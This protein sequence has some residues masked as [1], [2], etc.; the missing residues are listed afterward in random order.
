[1]GKTLLRQLDLTTTDD[2]TREDKELQTLVKCLA[3]FYQVQD[4]R[5]FNL[6]LSFGLAPRGADAI[7]HRQLFFFDL[8]AAIPSPAR[9]LPLISQNDEETCNDPISVQR[10][11]QS[12][13]QYNSIS[14]ILPPTATSSPCSCSTAPRHATS[15]RRSKATP[16]NPW[17]S[18]SSSSSRRKGWD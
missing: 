6:F 7:D 11:G 12:M 4:D 5:T 16:A 8:L 13:I 17:S 14:T 3:N 15:H 10:G 9:T 1:V 18:S 2:S